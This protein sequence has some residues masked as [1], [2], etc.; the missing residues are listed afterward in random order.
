LQNDYGSWQGCYSNGQGCERHKGIATDWSG[1]IAAYLKFHLLECGV[2]EDSALKLIRAS[3]TPQAFQGAINANMKDGKVILA[4]KAELYDDMED[5]M[6]RACWVNMTKGMEMSERVQYEHEARG[7]A[8][9]LNPSNPEALNLSDEQSMKSLNTQI[10]GGTAYMAALLASLGNTAYMPGN[11]DIDSQ[12]SDLFDMD[13]YSSIKNPFNMVVDGS[14]IT[15][16]QYVSGLAL[17]G[18]DTS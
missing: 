4:G 14:I 15:N 1:S 12:E 17:A 18:E 7:Q 3:C 5:M 2:T 13:N 6:K 9:L 16:L 8:H 10:P 11:E